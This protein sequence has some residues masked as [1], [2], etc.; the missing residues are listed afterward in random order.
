MF[1]IAIETVKKSADRNKK[2]AGL[3]T[4]FNGF[5]PEDKR[6]VIFTQY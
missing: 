1:F 3:Q 2:L 5:F 4:L 6:K